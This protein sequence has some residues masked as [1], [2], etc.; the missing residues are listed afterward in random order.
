M[1]NL[2]AYSGRFRAL[3]DMGSSWTGFFDFV[4]VEAV[5]EAIAGSIHESATGLATVFR[6]RCAAHKIPVQGLAAHLE[7]QLGAPLEVVGV[8][9]WLVRAGRVGLGGA[10]SLLIR[11]MLDGK[12]GGVVPWLLNGG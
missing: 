5:A 7:A 10:A 8:E 12:T 6:H 2:M 3:P 1:Q 4:P 11:N 9:E